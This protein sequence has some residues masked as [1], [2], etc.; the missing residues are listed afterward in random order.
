VQTSR[1]GRKQ[2]QLASCRWHTCCGSCALVRSSSWNPQTANAQQ[3]RC[4]KGLMRH[5]VASCFPSTRVAASRNSGKT[6]GRTE[7][8]E[9][10]APS[11]HSPNPEISNAQQCRCHKELMRHTV[12][13]CFLSAKLDATHGGELFPVSES[14]CFSQ[15]GKNLGADG[16]GRNF[17][18]RASSSGPTPNWRA[19][20]YDSGPEANT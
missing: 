17:R 3:R 19:L 1:R 9:T 18:T 4:H 10:L 14:C 8:A 11:L 7:G 13:S 20:C 5:T 12:A 6:P 15:L 16:R 2:P